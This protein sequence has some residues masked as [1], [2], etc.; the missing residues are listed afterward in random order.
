[1]IANFTFDDVTVKTSITVK[2]A[3]DSP[4]LVTIAEF[5]SRAKKVAHFCIPPVKPGITDLHPG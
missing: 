3:V 2:L 4:T 1:M 5:F